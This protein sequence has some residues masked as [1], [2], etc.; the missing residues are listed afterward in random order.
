M[1][2]LMG[3]HNAAK[4]NPSQECRSAAR[5]LLEQQEHRGGLDPAGD[6]AA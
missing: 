2:S 1:W 6:V 3:E 5:T 4:K